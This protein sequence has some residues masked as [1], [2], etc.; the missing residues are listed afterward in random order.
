MATQFTQLVKQAK[1][2]DRFWTVSNL[3]SLFRFCLLPPIVYF[4]ISHHAHSNYIALSLMVLAYLTDIFDG[5][6]ARLKH[7]ETKI[8]RILDPVI[9]KLMINGILISLVF[10]RN[11]PLW[12]AG[13]VLFRDTSV[14]IFSYTLFRGRDIVLKSNLWGKSTAFFLGALLFLYVGLPVDIWT[15]TYQHIAIGICLTLIV[16]SGVNYLNRFIGEITK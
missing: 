13:L 14:V 5:Y 3:L 11:L 2:E 4:L 16:G 1:G 9:D 6:Y 15:E 7:E 8:G 12:F 10:S